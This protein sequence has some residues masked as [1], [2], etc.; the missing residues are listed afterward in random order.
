MLT[1]TLAALAAFPDQLE[2]HFAA[3]AHEHRHWTPASWE[4]VPSEP[5][6]AIEQLCHV[7]DIEVEGYQ[8]RLRRTLEEDNPLL[9]SLDGEAMARERRYA[10]ADADS[11]LADFRRARRETLALIESI[12]AEQFLRPA[13]F[14]GYGELTLRSLV[15]YLCSH[16]QQHLAGLQWLLGKIEAGDRT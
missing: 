5:F 2:A 11:V 15:H 12:S 10:E 6:S 8:L 4:G 9:I 13:R 7:R 3:F 14:E 16:D 1:T